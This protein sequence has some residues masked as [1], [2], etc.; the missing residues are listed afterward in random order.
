MQN[1]HSLRLS[2]PAV[3]LRKRHRDSYL[4]RLEYKIEHDISE[5]KL[6]SHLQEGFFFFN[7]KNDLYYLQ[8]NKLLTGLSNGSS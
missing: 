2:L 8:N 3:M 7:C 1:V 6:I 4:S 5:K